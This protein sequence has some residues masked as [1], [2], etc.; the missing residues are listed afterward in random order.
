MLHEHNCEDYKLSLGNQYNSDK[1]NFIYSTCFELYFIC[2]LYIMVEQ[3]KLNRKEY[4]FN[5]HVHVESVFWIYAS[6]YSSVDGAWV[7]DS[8]PAWPTGQV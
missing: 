6:T 1:Y 7:T 3:K 5:I 2:H 4:D 8:G